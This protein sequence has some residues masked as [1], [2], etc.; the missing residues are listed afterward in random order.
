MRSTRWRLDS[1]KEWIDPSYIAMA[2]AGIGDKD[3]AMQWLET[4]VRD[5]D[6]LHPALHELERAPWLRSMQ[7]DPRFVALKK[8]VLATTG[9][10][11]R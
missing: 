10:A 8:K 7:D 6:V 9:S 5:E 4:G 3:N 1:K 11:N 2:Y